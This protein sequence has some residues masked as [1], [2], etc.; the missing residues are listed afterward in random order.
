VQQVI[1]V[2]RGDDCVVEVVVLME[3]EMIIR[4][5]FLACGKF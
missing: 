1:V 2:V 5:L 4:D 3:G